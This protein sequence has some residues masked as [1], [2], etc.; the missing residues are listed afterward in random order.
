MENLEGTPSDELRAIRRD[1]G[2]DV[3]ESE[4]QFHV[5]LAEKS[6]ALGIEPQPRAD[7]QHADSIDGLLKAAKEQGFSNTQQFADATGLSPVLVTM[8]DRGLISLPSIPPE[9]L[10]KVASTIKRAVEALS[11]YL[12]MGPRLAP[13]ASYKA[14]DAP[15]TEDPQDFFDAVLADPTLSEDRRERLLALRGR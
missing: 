12:Q 11:R 6:R 10:D 3:E 1:L 7:S 13:G 2:H 5:M 14:E 9:I 15:A 8:L 4:R